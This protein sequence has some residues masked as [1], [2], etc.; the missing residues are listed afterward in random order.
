LVGNISRKYNR[1]FAIRDFDKKEGW[2]ILR[3]KDLVILKTNYTLV[4]QPKTKS[5]IE[6]MPKRIYNLSDAVLV[7]VVDARIIFATRDI[8]DL[9]PRGVTAARL[10]A[11]QLANDAFKDM[12]TDAWWEGQESLKVE[13]RDTA[14]NLL[15][16][17]LG[18]LR[19]M[20][21]NVWGDKSVKYASYKFEG[22][23]SLE[24]SKLSEF[25]RGAHKQAT[26]D[27]AALLAEGALLLFYLRLKTWLKIWM[28]R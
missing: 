26:D 4:P 19:T 20:A 15:L 11:L 21:Q 23:I 22:M 24:D 27:A 12:P 8:A 3:V 10:A 28:I 6:E 1:Y 13:A 25:A 16:S 17:K 2:K 9:E 5:M 18:N 14:R 7:Q